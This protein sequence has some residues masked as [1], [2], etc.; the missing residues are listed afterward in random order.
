MN[1]NNLT[2]RYEDVQKLTEEEAKGIPATR[3]KNTCKKKLLGYTSKHI[4]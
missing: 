1:Q 3:N 2:D 4:Y